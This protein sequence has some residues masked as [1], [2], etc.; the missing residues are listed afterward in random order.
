[1]ADKSITVL[2]GDGGRPLELTAGAKVLTVTYGQL[3]PMIGLTDL[4]TFDHEWRERGFQVEH[5]LNPTSDEL[6]RMAQEHDVVFINLY[7]TPMMSLGTVRMT[8]SFRT[9]GWRSLFVEHPAVAYTA[10]GSPYVA[11]E[12]PHVPNLIATYGGSDVSQRAAVKV[13]LGEIE[14]RGTLPVRMPQVKIRPLQTV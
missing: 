14:A 8:E 1:M 11:Y 4:E 2:R 9:W 5:L 10:F 13:W 3:Y 6:R 12:L 7:F